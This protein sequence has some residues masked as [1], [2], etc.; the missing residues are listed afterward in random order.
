MVQ[1]RARVEECV[2]CRRLVAIKDNLHTSPCQSTT[3]TIL[4]AVKKHAYGARATHQYRRRRGDRDRHRAPENS[5]VG[6]K[7]GGYEWTGECRGWD[8][9]GIRR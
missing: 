3:S 7:D 4:Q 1:V 9:L 2:N 6:A 5:V 8:S